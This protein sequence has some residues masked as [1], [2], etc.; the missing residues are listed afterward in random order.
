MT[1]DEHLVIQRS[2]LVYDEGILKHNTIVVLD[3]VTY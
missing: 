3:Y 1:G 2:D